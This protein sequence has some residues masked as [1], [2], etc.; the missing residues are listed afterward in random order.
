MGLLRSDPVN[1]SL[2]PQAR[3]L[4][5]AIAG[6]ESGG[7]YNVRYTPGGGAEFA[8]LS[9]H[10][11]IMEPTRDGRK[12]SAAGRYQFTKSTW[13]GL[14]GGDFSPAN[15]DARAWQ[16]AQQDYKS[17]TG[18]N[19]DTDLQQKG[20]TPDIQRA[21]APTWEALH[22]GFDA[23]AANYK[24]AMSR[25]GAGGGGTDPSGVLT[26]ANGE[27]GLKANAPVGFAGM[28]MPMAQGNGNVAGLANPTMPGAASPVG[29]LG[30]SAPMQMPA[31]AMPQ[32]PMAS[33][34]LT[35]MASANEAGSGL[36]GNG[37][38]A[39]TLG[40]LGSSLLSAAQPK[41][42]TQLAALWNM[43]MQNRGTI[44]R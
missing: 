39:S 7:R 9:Q 32:G 18:S 13:D 29:L 25:F 42:D 8:D 14:G 28:T 2:P 11:G 24:D 4:L 5:N 26:Q 44:H 35:P 38:T 23:K 12:S 33:A 34:N 27:I 22:S 30:G 43:A 19:L 10:P 37:K 6:Q 1:T 41:E 21:L 31:D 3:A 20:Y 17:R 40:G 36:L 15:Q 16:L